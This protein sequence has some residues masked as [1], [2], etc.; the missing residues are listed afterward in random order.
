VEEGAT[1]AGRSAEKLLERTG[2]AVLLWGTRLRSDG[3]VV[4]LQQTTQ[5]QFSNVTR[6]RRLNVA[7]VEPPRELRTDIT[8]VVSLFVRRELC[9]IEAEWD[10]HFIVDKLD[11]GIGNMRQLLA[12]APT[13]WNPAALANLQCALGYALTLRGEQAGCR[14]S[15]AES[16]VLLRASLAHHTRARSRANWSLVQNNL[17]NALNALGHLE[18]GTALLHEAAEAHGEVLRHC[19]RDET[20][21]P[22]FIRHQSECIQICQEKMSQL[23]DLFAELRGAG[24]V[25]SEY[26]NSLESVSAAPTIGATDRC[27]S[28]PQICAD[29]A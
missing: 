23:R 28:G 4:R 12:N 14:E 11:A 10:G 20:P 19:P 22:V 2:A 27:L 29:G 6:S 13:D 3:Y 21:L 9:R 17:G 1:R 18:P 7:D 26:Q 24:E 15:L 16:I 25:Y 5:P 8:G